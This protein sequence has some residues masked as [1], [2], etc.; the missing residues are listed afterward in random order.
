M[1]SDIPVLQELFDFQAL[2]RKG[3][4][5]QAPEGIL[6]RLELIGLHRKSDNRWKDLAEALEWVFT[7]QSSTN[8]HSLIALM[9][10]RKWLTT[11]NLDQLLLHS[12]VA[13]ETPSW[14]ELLDP[15]LTSLAILFPPDFSTQPRIMLSMCKMPLGTES[16]TSRTE[17]LIPSGTLLGQLDSL[18]QFNFLVARRTDMA[19]ALALVPNYRLLNTLCPI[20][21]GNRPLL[22]AC[23][24]MHSF[25][26]ERWEK[27][28]Q[29]WRGDKICTHFHED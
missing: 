15:R 27:A 9:Q 23:C 8:H 5:S 2:D 28:R 10:R 11:S 1:N 21:S 12:S 19:R 26:G 17:P 20:Q 29:Y 4:C 6:E 3:S 13:S 14:L 18:V 22:P 25:Y 7:R 24:C 16:S